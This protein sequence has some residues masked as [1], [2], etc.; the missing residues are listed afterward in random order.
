M[1]LQ[2]I[3]KLATAPIE[4][5]PDLAFLYSQISGLNPPRPSA[6]PGDEGPLAADLEK[7]LVPTLLI[8]GEEDAIAPVKVMQALRGLIPNSRLEVVLGAAHSTYFEQPA[9][10]N[11]LVSD[12]FAQVLAETAAVAADD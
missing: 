10:F 12:F 2:L 9:E 8:V 7:L 1:L 3:P 11:R 6:S 4:H 5:L